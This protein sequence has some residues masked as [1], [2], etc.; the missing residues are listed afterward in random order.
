MAGLTGFIDVQQGAA[1]VVVADFVRADP[2]VRHVAIGARD[3]RPRVDALAPEF[4]FRVLGFE[5]GCPGVRMDPVLMAHFI[6]VGQD[7]LHFI[8]L[9]P[10]KNQALFGPFKVIL[11]MTLSAYVAAHLLAGRVAVHVIVVDALAAFQRANAF[12]ER[13]AGDPELQRLRVMAIDTGNRMGHFFPGF[14]VGQ[15]IEFFET[16]GQISVPGFFVRLIHGGVAIKAGAGLRF[17]LPA[18][19]GLVFEHVGM[20]ALLAEIDGEGIT[21]PHLFQARIFLQL[22]LG[23]Y[24]TRI[25]VGGGARPR[26]AAAIPG[27]D[28]VHGLEVGVVLEG[29]VLAPDRRVNCVIGQVHHPEK[30]VLGFLLVL[31]D[32]HQQ[33]QPAYREQ[34][35]QA[36]GQSKLQHLPATLAGRAL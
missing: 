29:K 16:L 24:R 23:H 27:A 1:H 31:H 30:R 18:G 32:V 20:A 13:R 33:C 19:K 4:K 15:G 6:V 5:G 26:V 10:G 7:V 25:G 3:A 28:L 21:G 2:L 14:G 11:D 8:S 34:R 35:G 22:G 17:G 36:D 12:H 9:G